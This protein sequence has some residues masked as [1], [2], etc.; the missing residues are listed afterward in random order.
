MQ[1]IEQS[2]ELLN[3]ILT[4]KQFAWGLIAVSVILTLIDNFLKMPLLVGGWHIVMYILILAPLTYLAWKSELRNRYTKWLLPF[5]FIMIVD[6]FYYNNGMVQ[7]VL[8]VIFYIYVLLLYITSMQKVE[9]IYQTILPKISFKISILEYA[10]EF[11]SNLI[12]YKQDKG[13]YNRIGIALLITVPFLGIFILLLTSA[14]SHYSNI[15]SGIFKLPEHF[16]IHYILT[17]PLYFAIYLFGFIYTLS[18]ISN[19]V[20]H[21]ETKKLDILIIGIFLGVINLLFFSFVVLQIPFLL[22]QNYVP[23][24]VSI[25]T[26]AREGFFQ[27]MLV[28][29]LVSVIFLYILKRYR[30]EKI[31]T[32]LLSIMLIQTVIIGFVSLKKMHLYQ[33]LMGATVLRYYVEWFD[34]F[35]IIILLL[36][37]WFL[38]RKLSFATFSNILSIIAIASFTLI[39]SLNIDA[40]VAKTNIE[41]FKDNPRKLDIEALRSLSIDA[42]P[43]LKREKVNFKGYRYWYIEPRR[44][45]SKFS[46]YHY[47]YCS[48]EP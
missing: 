46:T 11:A 39:V 13:I 14:D 31:V 7:Y 44:D 28:L 23:Q 20:G 48:I 18:N 8:P 1:Q 17:V 5:A 19:R 12:T 24:G 40:I 34:Y 6:M 26:F 35:L 9:N 27:L 10:K 2:K 36:G 30:G 41:K 32:Y 4:N 16:D 3:P 38:I 45:C 47:G 37:V 25:S 21:I 43:V 15:L 22:S 29:S 33:S 42:L